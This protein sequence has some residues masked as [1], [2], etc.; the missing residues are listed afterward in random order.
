MDK[1]S[2]SDSGLRIKIIALS[3]ARM[4]RDDNVVENTIWKFWKNTLVVLI[5]LRGRN[6]F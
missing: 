4:L 6:L 1:V 5:R 2:E 3:V